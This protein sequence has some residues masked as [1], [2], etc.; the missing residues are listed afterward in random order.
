MNWLANQHKNRH[1]P[2]GRKR[3]N[4]THH[5]HLHAN[6]ETPGEEA[7]DALVIVEENPAAA[8][9]YSTLPVKI[10]IET[11]NDGDQNND[12]VVDD[13]DV[14]EGPP[15]VAFVKVIYLAKVHHEDGYSHTDDDYVE[16]GQ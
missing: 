7:D 9:S 2:I 12:K 15:P 5:R 16:D 10:T 6:H 4:K 1:L 14:G 8:T 11:R 13:D 3:Q